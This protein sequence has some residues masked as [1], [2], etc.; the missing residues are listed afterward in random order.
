MSKLNSISVE[1]LKNSASISETIN[2]IYPPIYYFVDALKTGSIVSFLMFMAT[3]L[4]PFFIFVTLFAKG[5]TKINARM[6]ESYKTKNYKFK[7][8][9]F[10]HLKGS[11]EKEFRRYT[12]SFIYF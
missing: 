11:I 7:S 4:I 5:F 12:S 1:L 8:Q 6:G 3:S 10:Q 9:K 2:K